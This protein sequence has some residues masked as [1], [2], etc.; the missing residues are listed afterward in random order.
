VTDDVTV[1]AKFRR[2]FYEV[3]L[4]AGTGGTIVG[5]YALNVMDNH[6]NGVVSVG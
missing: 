1:T 5:T 6:Y 2:S 3:T 4:S